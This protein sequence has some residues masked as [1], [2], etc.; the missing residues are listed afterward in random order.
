MHN[1]ITHHLTTTIINMSSTSKVPKTSTADRFPSKRTLFLL[2]DVQEKCRSVVPHFD[3]LVVNTQKLIK[4]GQILDV[5]LIVTEQFPERFG[6]TVKELNIDHRKARYTKLQFSMITPDVRTKIHKLFRGENKL[7][8][9]V[10]FGIEV[11][12][13]LFMYI[14][15]RS[16]FQ[17]DP[18]LTSSIY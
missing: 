9:V 10:L 17:L 13:Q 7:R 18:Y 16:S 2:C 4:A 1:L 15:F 6:G 3:A 5:P 14:L 12:F 11:S 8:S